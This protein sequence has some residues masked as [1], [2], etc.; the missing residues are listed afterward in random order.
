M[1]IALDL[2]VVLDVLQHRQPHYQDSADVL[3]RS[4]TGEITAILSG[5]GVTT[6]WYILD[7]AASPVTAN[8][9]VDWLLNHFEIAA[10]E[11]AAFQDARR[12]PMTDFEDAVVATLAQR[13]ECDYI[14]TRNVPDFAGSPVPAI[15]PTD[16]LNL[17]PAPAPPPATQSPGQS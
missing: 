9:T 2:H 3:S 17:L 10:A 4:R 5:H 14:V 7:K 12:L 11:K 1:T 16:F 8:Q 6:L 13:A 15:T